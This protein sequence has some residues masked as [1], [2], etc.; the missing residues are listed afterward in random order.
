MIVLQNSVIGCFSPLLPVTL[1]AVRGA[2]L[3]TTRPPQPPKVVEA[4][5]TIHSNLNWRV[6]VTVIGSWLGHVSLDTT[7]LY[8]QASLETKRKALELV[9]GCA[10]STRI[11][12]CATK[13]TAPANSR[14][15]ML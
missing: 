3:G 8:A 14:W 15:Y 13:D 10:G 11:N 12:S 1:F 2:A 7:N 9:D 5:L 4:W 6:D